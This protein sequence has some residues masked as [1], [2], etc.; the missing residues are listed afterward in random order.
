MD[1]SSRRRD[2]SMSQF[3]IECVC[4]CVQIC[5]MRDLEKS[6]KQKL[7][8]AEKAKSQLQSDLSN[9]DR[10]IQQLQSVNADLSFFFFSSWYN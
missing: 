8:T 3:Y 1:R 9:R 5:S 6:L 2:V 10:T 4:V 7:S